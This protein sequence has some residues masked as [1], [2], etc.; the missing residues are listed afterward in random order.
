MMAVNDD[1]G[2]REQ[3]KRA[4]RDAILAAARDVFAR[5]GYGATTVRDIIRATDLASGTFYNYFKSKEE[6]FEAIQDESALR[7]RP[8][9]RAER[10]RAR[11]VEEF[12]AGTFHTFFDYVAHDRA[13]FAAIRRNVDTVRIRMDSQEVIAGFDE[14]KED[15]VTAMEAGLFPKVDADY[16]MASFVGIGFEIAEYMLKREPCDPKGAAGFATALF[17]GGFRALPLKG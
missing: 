16:L 13:T 5:L 2:K 4:N 6:V 10:I 12:V 7:L 14:L 17:M 15:I 9:L 1:I 3:T 11:N 8:R